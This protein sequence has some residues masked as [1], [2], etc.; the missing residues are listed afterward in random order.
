MLKIKYLA[1]IL[2]S[3]LLAGCFRYV[4][5]DQEE[6]NLEGIDIDQTL[7]IAEIELKE[8]G[9]DSVL[10]LWAIRNQIINTEEAE[11]ISNIYLD[12]IDK[13]EGKSQGAYEFSIWHFAWAIADLY[14]VNN[15]EVKSVLSKAYNNAI[16]QPEKL[17]KFDKISEL[18]INSEKIYMGDIHGLGRSYARKHL[19]VPGNNKYIQ[20]FDEYLENKKKFDKDFD[21]EK[22]LNDEDN[23]NSINEVSVL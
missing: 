19:I 2:I 3:I 22:Y 7:K 8:G 21:I 5:Y 13:I 4:Y 9:I 20:S 15:D 11:K 14:R 1:L 16:N 12:N 18:L 17:E 10:T 6:V 23:I